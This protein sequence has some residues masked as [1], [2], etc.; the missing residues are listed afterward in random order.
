MLINKMMIIKVLKIILKAHKMKMICNKMMNRIRMMMMMM[1][2]LKKL[3]KEIVKRK[4][5]RKVLKMK[6]QKKV[7]KK[8]SMNRVKH[9]KNKNLER[10]KCSNNVFFL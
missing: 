7:I 4:V 2:L 5:K 3:V 6:I 10:L 1:V 8:M 9:Q